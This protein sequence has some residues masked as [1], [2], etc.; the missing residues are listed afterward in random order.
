MPRER[1]SPIEIENCPIMFLNFA[2]KGTKFNPEGKRNFC[3]IIEDE[4]LADRLRQDGWNVKVLPSR[5]PDEPDLHYIQV[6]VSYDYNPPRVYMITSRNKTKL[7]EESV[8]AMD[9]A[10][11]IRDANGRKIVDLIIS[12][13]PWEVNGKTG[14]KAYLKCLY[15]TIEEDRFE[16][17]YADIND[18][19][20]MPF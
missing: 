2:G 18:E 15:A 3:A 10:E 14:I 6:S 17:K 19:E 20:D 4:G 9:Y 16:A 1:I 7:D 8:E 5:D 11:I 12:P 13:Y